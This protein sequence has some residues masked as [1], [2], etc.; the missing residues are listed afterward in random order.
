ML[1]AQ[2]ETLGSLVVLAFSFTLVAAQ[3][4]SRYSHVMLPRVIG[5]WALWY[6]I[7]YGVG[8]L[9]PLFLLR[10]DFFLWSAHLSLILAT[11]CVLSLVPYA[12]AVR[13]LLSIPEAMTGM[14]REVATT[15]DATAARLITSL[16]HIALGALNLK[17][18]ETFAQGIRELLSCAKIRDDVNARMLV[19]A[20]LRGLVVRTADEPFA[21]EALCKAIF[22]LGIESGIEERSI[23]DEKVL[24]EVA[25]S[26][27]SANST[28]FR[29]YTQEVALIEEY[30]RIAVERGD[31]RVVRTLQ[32]IL[33]VV[34]ER[35]VQEAPFEGAL[36]Q[37]VVAALGNTALRVLDARERFSDHVSLVKSVILAV[38][39]LGTR[40]STA[41]RD[42]VREWAVRQLARL[43]DHPADVGN[44]F[45]A[46]HVPRWQ[47]W[48]RQH[49]GVGS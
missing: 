18:Y 32:R 13:R 20:E 4:A 35:V 16:G 21:S 7:P 10:G 31:S 6:A 42:E 25:E 49:K 3:I 5:G 14:A 47:S 33:Y 39:Y 15:D 40:G 22:G 23:S 41:Q 28:C 29:D 46:A 26:Y 45:K 43:V 9:L 1:S 37:Q 11:Y 8:I 36:A 34:G 24:N 30:A 19:A 2:A 38:E 17:D 48:A 44:Q 27:R 12:A